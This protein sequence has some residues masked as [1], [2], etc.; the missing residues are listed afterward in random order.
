MKKQPYWRIHDQRLGWGDR[1]TGGVEV[2][3]VPGDH[4]SILREP[5]VVE[6]A[7]VLDAR[8]DGAESPAAGPGCAEVRAR[9]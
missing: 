5:H 8:I 9:P 7:R 1:T 2:Y 4:S 3:D 6:I